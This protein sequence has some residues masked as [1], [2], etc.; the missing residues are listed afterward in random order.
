MKRLN[1]LPSICQIKPW[2]PVEGKVIRGFEGLD[3]GD[4]VHVELRGTDVVRKPIDFARPGER[5][6]N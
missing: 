2:L 6:R 5:Q 1:R 3:V 4:R